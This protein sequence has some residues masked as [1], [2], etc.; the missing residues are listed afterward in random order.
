MLVSRLEKSLGIEVYITRSRGIG[1]VIRLFPEDFMVEEILVDGS[2]AEIFP[3]T[4][5]PMI[6]E[7]EPFAQHHLLCI[8][9]KR[10]W[11]NLQAVKA[12]ARRLGVSMRQLG[13]AGLKDARALTAQHI[14]I[15]GVNAED[16]QKLQIKDLK[17]RPVRY[18]H[19]KLSPYLLLGNF[20]RITIRQLSRSKLH[21][22]EQIS[23]ISEEIKTLGG[24]P[25]FFGHQRF[26]TIRPIT[27]LVGKALVKGESRK[28]AMLF[29]AKPSPN[30]HPQSR[31]AREELWKTQNFKKALKMFPKNLYY[32]RLM[33]K[34]LVKKPED[35][36][37]AIR[38]LPIKLQ[39]LFP[40]AYQAYLFNKILSRRI[41]Q[42]FPINRAEVGDYVVETE[43]SGLPNVSKYK[44]VSQES[45]SEINKAIESGKV[46]L[47]I[48]L[49]GF[50][51]SF[52]QGVQG[53]I[54]KAVLDE[55][56]VSLKNFKIKGLPEL[57]LGGGLRAAL[58]R[59]KEF[60]LL[61]I[62]GDETHPRKSK[63][64]MSFMLYRGSY[65]TAVLR[66]FMKPRNPVKAGF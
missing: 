27:H 64:I 28:A 9:V 61:E 39:R 66:E 33:L 4:E 5:T 53:E 30:E 57:S 59:I 45:I 40:E 8:L 31:E 16:V 26:G 25:N 3:S 1:G 48:P 50:K 47:A 35:F 58:A 44:I 22:Q 14:T 55:E 56:S 43:P 46:L 63:A 52:S 41:A 19:I 10:D 62:S 11:D 6:K 65:A 36:I 21:L 34:H 32:E 38:R 2:R 24:V 51:Q 29:L 15:E 54:E 49:A 7:A 42:G 13:I 60:S 12:I 37:G 17:V 18:F 23:K 20:F